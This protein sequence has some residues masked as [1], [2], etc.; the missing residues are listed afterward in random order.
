M[1]YRFN[2]DA[3]NVARGD[4]AD[5]DASL[6]GWFGGDLQTKLYEEVIGLGG[7]GK[8]LTILTAS[9]LPDPERI[10]EEEELVESWE[11]KFRR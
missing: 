9:D 5:G 2:S 11:P 10:Q 6:Q 8:T 1:T 3:A 7:Y 4:R